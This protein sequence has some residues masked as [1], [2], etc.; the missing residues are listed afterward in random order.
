MI[1]Q[2]ARGDIKVFQIITERMDREVV[3]ENQDKS[4]GRLDFIQYD[5]EIM[6]EI[7]DLVVKAIKKQSCI[8]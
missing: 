2:A 4:S 3:K 6:Q 7:S 1:K 8:K 5:P